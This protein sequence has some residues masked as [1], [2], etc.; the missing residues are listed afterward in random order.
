MMRIQLDI[1]GDRILTS[2][3]GQRWASNYYKYL[4]GDV[5]AHNAGTG[6]LISLSGLYL[7]IPN[8]LIRPIKNGLVGL[9]GLFGLFGLIFVVLSTET[10]ALK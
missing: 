8:G 10:E 3:W 9:F 1:D 7:K 5:S 2:C 6:E 4:V